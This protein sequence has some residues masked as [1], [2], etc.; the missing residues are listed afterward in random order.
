M[1]SYE[2]SVLSTIVILL[3]KKHQP[4]MLWNLDRAIAMIDQPS[5]VYR[6]QKFSEL[7]LEALC[8]DQ[9]YF[10]DPRAFNDPLDCQPCVESDSD[11]EELRLIFA[12]LLRKRVESETL[13][14]L[15]KVNLVGTNAEQHAKSVAEQHVTN[16][17]NDISYHATNPDYETSVD[18]AECRLL[19]YAIEN[20]L[21]K[22]YDRGICCFSSSEI[23][24]LLWSHY[25][26][27]HHGICVGYDLNRTPKPN[28]HK[29]I[30]GGNRII[31]TS[32]IA[33]AIVDEK[34][35]YQA[36]LDRDVLLRKAQPWSYEEEWRLLGKRG[37]QD[38]TLAL[39]DIT[40][41]LRCSLGVKHAVI[42]ALKGR[43]D[44]IDFYEIYQKRGS[45]ELKKQPIDYEYLHG[46]PRTAKSG[47]E[48][49]GQ[50]PDWKL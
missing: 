48:I 32:S 36:A 34:A 50:V 6:Y 20:E 37:I 16:E 7:S 38:S 8:R 30:Y 39:K 42:S 28:L 29:V 10:S 43:V 25:G 46:L 27:Q 9:L 26:D 3:N 14:S 23:N 17:L 12:K 5:K 4:P 19:T 31:H 13:A 40:F 2:N 21:L 11:R 44:G 1:S 45:F 15:K 22:Q 41:G 49:F 24:P 47:Q 35:D 18:E 33:K